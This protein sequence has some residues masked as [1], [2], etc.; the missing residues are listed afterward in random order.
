MYLSKMIIMYHYGGIFIDSSVY[1]FKI[2]LLQ[3]IEN[4]NKYFLKLLEKN[5]L[6]HQI[7]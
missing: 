4:H 1:N 2:D 7:F 3:L 5:Q 6:L